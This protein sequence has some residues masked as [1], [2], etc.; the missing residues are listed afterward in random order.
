M[1]TNPP[2]HEHWSAQLVRI[3]NQ[4]VREA[5]TRNRQLG[6]PN[7]YSLNGQLLSDAP[8]ATEPTPHT[9]QQGPKA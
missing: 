5:Q 6:I 9:G 4:A 7:W 1:K 2:K 8:A 3:G